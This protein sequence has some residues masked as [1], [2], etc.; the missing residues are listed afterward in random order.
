MI[1]WYFLFYRGL[2]ASGSQVKTDGK[3]SIEDARLTDGGPHVAHGAGR[4]K[5]TEVINYSSS[6]FVPRGR[7]DGFG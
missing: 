2:K 7:N 6:C 3:R 1:H 4:E 5:P